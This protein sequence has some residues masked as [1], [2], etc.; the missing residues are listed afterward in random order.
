MV[1]RLGRGRNLALPAHRFV[2]GG[3]GELD[4]FDA[5]DA[6]V[7]RLYTKRFLKKALGLAV[8]A[9]AGAVLVEVG[10]DTE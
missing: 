8:I 9:I 3:R 7:A 2:E 6:V 10:R 1:N 5:T 4:A